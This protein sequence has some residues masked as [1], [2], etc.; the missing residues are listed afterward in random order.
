MQETV[1]QITATIAALEGQRAI[2]GNAVVDVA[3][4][5]LKRE[6]AARSNLEARGAQ[7]LKQVSVLFVDVVGSTAIG[8]QLGPEDIHAV[9]DSAL[10]RFTSIV[11]AHHGRV[12]QYTGDGMLAAFGSEQANEDDVESAIKAGLRIIDD[13]LGLALTMRQR[14]GIP[15]FSVRAGIHTGT[16]L[17]GGGVDAEGSIR[18][19]TVNVAA[20]MEQSAPPG[21]LRISHDSYRHVRGLFD[22]TEQAPIAVKGVEEPLRTYLVDRVKPR[23]FRVPTRGI[24]GVHTPMVGREAELEVLCAAFDEAVY[25]RRAHVVNVV[26]DAGLGKSRLLGEFQDALNLRICWLLLGRA[27]PRSAVQP[28]GLLRD[29]FA[30]QFQIAEGDA[31]EDGRRKLL[32]G[33]APLFAAEGEAP[34]HLIGQLIGLDFSTSAHVQEVLGDERLFR[35]R[36]FDAGALCIRRLGEGRPVVV[37]LDDLHWSDAGTR[38]FMRHLLTCNGDTPLLAVMMSR[39]APSDLRAEWDIDDARNQLLELKP[40]DKALSHEL[41]E[42]LLQR[43]P[44]VPAALRSLLTAGAEGNPFYMEE[45]VKMLIDDGVIVVE[46]DEWRVL[47]DK[48]LQAHVPPTLTGV[49]QARID[50]LA[51]RERLT[52]QQAAVVGHVFWDRALAAIDADAAEVLPVLLRKRLIVPRDT[53]AFEDTSEYAFQHNLLHQVTYDGI[54]KAPKRL[55][56]ANVGAFWSRRAEVDSPQ[57]VTPATCR[58]LVEAHYH[59]CKADAQGYVGWFDGQFSN[60]LN[61][62]FAQALRPLAQQ[63]I[64][65]CEQQFGADHAETAKALT[66][67]ARVILQLGGVDRAEPLLRRAIAIQEKALP[68]DHPDMARTLAVLGG[69]YSGR[70]DLAAAEPFIRRALD[71]RE[72][73]LG[74]EHPLTLGIRD[75]LAK[76][77]LELGRLDEAEALTRQVLTAKERS[78]GADHPD[79]AFALTALGEVLTKQGRFEAAEPLIRRALAVQERMLSVDHP[80]AGLSMWHLSEA[81]RGLRRCEEAERYARRAL[82]IWETKLGPDHEWTTWGLISLAE[83]RLIQ[84]AALEAA[85]LAERA[86]NLV[87]CIYGAA[88]AVMGSTL[89]LHARALLASGNAFAAEPLLTRALEIQS[90][91]GAISNAALEAASTL[92][93]RTRQELARR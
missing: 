11:Q 87:R 7:Q 3:L 38:D 66:N 18:G 84:G 76:V 31:A 12:L 65:V 50:A 70:G 88:H 81:L 34:I 47:P 20:R 25:Q 5:P 44:E 73:V 43:L 48:L 40:L 58:A 90:G 21:R 85:A 19:A 79:T 71:I 69:Y 63:M 46:A 39:P 74:I 8:Q 61:A 56:H 75:N 53:P 36:A 83:T 78:F 23:A 13:A 77:V 4:A 92:L 55:A 26:G 72:R 14:H 32:D 41:A 57:G 2:L 89:N 35:E 9:M 67:L 28:Y 93:E 80:E 91:L 30:R 17:L 24:E 37:V 45:L 52:L 42:S 10:E 60:Y 33:L 59:R 27:H 6:L 22:V 1:E 49:L 64:G 86:V 54:L 29:V 16:V 62:Y 82:E 68:A 51:P 15:E